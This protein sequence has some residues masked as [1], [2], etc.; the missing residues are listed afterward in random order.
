MAVSF[1]CRFSTIGSVPAA[2]RPPIPILVSSETGSAD[3][4]RD[5]FFFASGGVIDLQP[6]YRFL[7][8]GYE[9]VLDSVS[10]E[11]L[12]S[13]LSMLTQ[14]PSGSYPVPRLGVLLAPKYAPRDDVFGVM[15]DTGLVDPD[16]PARSVSTSPRAGCVIFLQ[17]IR[18]LRPNS[19]D[20]LKQVGF[21]IAHEVGHMFNL[22]HVD[23]NTGTSFLNISPKH[24]VPQ[25]SAFKF[26][27]FERSILAE[28]GIDRSVTPGGDPFGTGDLGN[29]DRPD[30]P[31]S[32]KSIRLVLAVDIA[33][34]EFWAW[35][36]VELDIN[37]SVQAGRSVQPLRVPDRLDPG[38]S[39]FEIW[40]EEAVRR[41][42]PLSFNEALLRA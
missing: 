16:A 41:T 15:F 14:N 40:I 22:Q 5:L 24:A 19:E 37:L 25:S 10:A 30:G 26:L 27:S 32:S 7:A 4:I 21:D 42:A 28:C 9:P 39:T 31:S 12:H 35:E 29:E 11:S 8:D 33:Q 23:S 34:K 20:Y 6:N 13:A 17:T 2:L 3:S 36:P 18:D 1:E 38:Y